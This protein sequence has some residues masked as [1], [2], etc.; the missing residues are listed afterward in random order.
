MSKP[1]LLCGLTFNCVKSQMKY[2][3][4]SAPRK[5]GIKMTPHLLAGILLLMVLT[6]LVSWGALL[7]IGPAPAHAQTPDGT[8]L[9][10]GTLTAG[11]G[12]YS[13][14]PA[15]GVCLITSSCNPSSFGSLPSAGFQYGGKSYS[16]R[17]LVTTS[18]RG[19][20]SLSQDPRGPLH[21]QTAFTLNVGSSR[22]AASYNSSTGIYELDGLTGWTSGQ[23][24][25]V[26]IARVV[27]YDTDDDNLI[28]IAN[29]AQLNAMRWDVDGNGVP[30]GGS[31]AAAF[32][33][34]VTNMGCAA[35]C[36]GYELTADLDFDTDGSGTA[37]A[38]D[39]YWRGGL[40]WGPIGT[41]ASPYTG[42]FHGNGHIISNLFIDRITAQVGLFGVLGGSGFVH[43]VGL[44]DVNVTTTM[45]DVGA[46][47]GFMKGANTR[48]AAS[49]V[50]TG[51]VNGAGQTGGLVGSAQ[52]QVAA[53]W[54]YVAVAGAAQVGGLV[55][56]NG[57]GVRNAYALGTVSGTGGSV[58]GA[59]GL[60][61]SSA[62]LVMSITIRTSIW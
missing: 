3:P 22:H 17:A 56:N 41:L 61:Q 27:D 10:T 25:Q 48:V 47:V 38:A 49:Y 7:P 14:T 52:G 59:V 6:V 46:L 45:H 12:T 29:L 18:T 37:N 50:G 1:T 62:A 20:L 13:D 5:W 15:V 42:V 33:N 28:E 57:G 23:T 51:S 44:L 35:T 58:H 2:I 19:L 4:L 54:T 32:P 43:H 8:T 24:Y 16:V 53:S 40:G 36:L 30:D 60:T 11:A 34:A 31:Y 26:S 21:D 55:G 9:W 39:T